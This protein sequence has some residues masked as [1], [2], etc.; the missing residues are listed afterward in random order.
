MILFE[1]RRGGTLHHV[2][3]LGVRNLDLTHALKK[4]FRVFFFFLR[5]PGAWR[6]PVGFTKI[7]PAPIGSML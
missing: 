5:N 2:R 4:Y 1:S 3:C 7:R 6:P